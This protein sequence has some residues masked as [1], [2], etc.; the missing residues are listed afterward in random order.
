MDFTEWL[1]RNN[2]IKS[3]SH[4]DNRVKIGDVLHEIQDKE[5]IIHHSFMPFIHYTQTL[6]HDSLQRIP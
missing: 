3:Y 4:F 5:N 1:K 2:T 6:I